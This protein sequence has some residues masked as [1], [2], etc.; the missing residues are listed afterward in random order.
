MQLATIRISDTEILSLSCPRI[1][2]HNGLVLLELVAAS[3]KHGARSVV[4]D[5]GPRTIID[6]SGARAVE[7]ASRFT[8]EKGTLFL[9]GLN[10]RARALLRATRVVEHV[11]LIEW[12]SDAIEGMTQQAA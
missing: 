11:K 8:G 6:F 9:A 12:W 7:A 3:V 2:A 4:L 10:S 1:D 5:L